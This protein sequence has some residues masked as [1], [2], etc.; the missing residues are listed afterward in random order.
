MMKAV[1]PE[2]P[3]PK[4]GYLSFGNKWAVVVLFHSIF[5]NLALFF[6]LLQ[7]QNKI[8]RMKT[9]QMWYRK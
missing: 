9:M 4:P 6:D 1:D 8:K 2:N 7:I 5:M 3:P